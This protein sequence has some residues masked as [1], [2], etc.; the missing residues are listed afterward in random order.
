[1]KKLIGYTLFWVGIGM[2]IMLLITNIC[3]GILLIILLLFLGFLLF[4]VE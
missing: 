2:L 1:M 3:I 4:D